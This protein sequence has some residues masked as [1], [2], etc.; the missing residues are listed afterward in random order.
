MTQAPTTGSED[1]VILEEMFVQIARNVTS[2]ESTLTLQT[3]HRPP[4]TSPT[5]QSGWLAT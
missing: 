1:M 4:C 5:V 3:S 2:D